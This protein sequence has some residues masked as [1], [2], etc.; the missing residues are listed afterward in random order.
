MHR[1]AIRV[2]LGFALALAFVGC[3]SHATK[4]AD[5]QKQ[6]DQLAKQY[7]QD[8]SG[9]YLNVPPKVSAKCKDEEM[10][11]NEAWK[12]LQTERSRK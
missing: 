12:R 3:R 6:Y 2:A 11:M 4:V 10:K 8:C 9:E 5:L 7:Q 1:T